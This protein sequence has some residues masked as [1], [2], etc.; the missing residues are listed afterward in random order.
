MNCI[1][2]SGTIKSFGE[3]GGQFKTLWI[4]VELT[5][6]EGTQSTVFINF[7]IDSTPNSKKAQKADYIKSRLV[8][9]ETIFISDA[10]VKLVSLSKPD[11]NGGWLKEEKVGLGGNISNIRLGVNIPNTNVALVEGNITK[12]NQESNKIVVEESY[13]LPNTNEWK[14]RPIPVLIDS[15]VAY[16]FEGNN[17]VGKDAFVIGTLVGT[18]SSVYIQATRVIT[19]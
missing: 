1:N 17:L 10:T 12:H 9:G 13:R 18:E 8:K 7:P 14:T 5:S 3:R 16:M 4:A 15:S 6:K 19:K 11:G 2:F